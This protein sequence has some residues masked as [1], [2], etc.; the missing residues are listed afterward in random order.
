M[1]DLSGVKAQKRTQTTLGAKV[2]S[3]RY[4]PDNYELTEDIKIEIHNKIS[5]IESYEDLDN[6]RLELTDRFGPVDEELL[7]YMYEKL[8]Y[9]LCK[10][11]GVENIDIKPK[12]I[13]LTLSEEK[14]SQ[15][16]GMYVYKSAYEMSNNFL[17][18][19]HDKKI[20]ISLKLGISSKKAWL[21]MLCEYLTKIV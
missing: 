4:I 12:I 17:L 8:F 5:C 15:S 2:I 19:Y 9:S 3:N 14:S 21:K 6:L 7:T 16:D 11:C 1:N 20:F 10:Q 18:S 13:T